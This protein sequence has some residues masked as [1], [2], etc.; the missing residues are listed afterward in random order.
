MDAHSHALQIVKQIGP[1][2]PVEISKRINTSIILASAILSELI[3]KGLIKVSK[4]KV[5]S[6]P[7]YYAPGQE[8]KLEQYAQNLGEKDNRA[9]R[10]LKEKRILIDSELSPLNQVAMRSIKDF[11][12]P[13]E[14]KFNDKTVLVWKYY[15]LTNEEAGDQIRGK[16]MPESKKPIQKKSEPKI[17]SSTQPINETFIKPR[18]EIK[19]ETPIS[20]ETQS[21]LTPTALPKDNF[22]DRIRT[23]LSQKNIE[24]IAVKIIR[25]NSE[26]DLELM[27]PTQVGK[28]NFFAKAKNKKSI[29]EGDIS[30]AIL[31]AENKKL[32][33]VFISP[34]KLSK[35]ADE[36]LKLGNRQVIFITL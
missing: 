6:S 35:K 28:M 17:K 3:G 8:S 7:L 36:F 14:V 18:S 4:V 30:T 34:G 13:I 10:L 9:Y 21:S 20:I 26:L 22:L 31:T 16:L 12:Y 2:L 29:N 19:S 23:T 1:T 11:A 33:L 25:K 27:V 15:L 5:G 24:I 32:P